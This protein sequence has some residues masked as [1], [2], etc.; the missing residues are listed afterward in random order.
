MS[1][2]KTKTKNAARQR[3]HDRLRRKVRGTAERPRLVVFRSNTGIYAQVVDDDAG[4]TLVASSSNEKGFPGP[5]GEGKAGVATVV[6]RLVA[7]RAKAAGIDR[8]VFDRGGNR[9]HGRVRALAE[10]ARDAGLEF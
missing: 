9:Y 3:R 5:D 2:A 8:V 1:S 4:R 10:G 6:G 7:E